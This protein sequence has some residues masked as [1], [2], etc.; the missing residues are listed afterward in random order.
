MASFDK[1]VISFLVDEVAG[2]FFVDVPPGH[3]STVYDKGRGVLR[4]T[5]G[6]GLHFKIPFW[7]K[8]KVFNAQ[9]IE[10]TIREGFNAEEN[11]EA[12]GDDPINATTSDNINITV[13]GTILVR[14]NKESIVSL[15][16]NIGEDFVSKIIR[17]VSRSRIRTA[18]SEFTYQQLNSSTRHDAERKIK[19]LVVA[20][21][22][23]KGLIVEGILLSDIIQT[24]LT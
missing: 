23:H 9:T 13:K 7:Q 4:T 3:I 6:P 16:E 24:N 18:L 21:L 17:P 11:K 1:L 8:A 2:G 19:D 10:Y 12:L 14:I 20:E 5:W 15:W 22:G